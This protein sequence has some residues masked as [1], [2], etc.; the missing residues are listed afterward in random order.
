MLMMMTT[1]KDLDY[2]YTWFK[3]FLCFSMAVDESKEFDEFDEI[4]IS[5]DIDQDLDSL[6]VNELVNYIE[7]NTEQKTLSE[8]FNF[9]DDVPNLMEVSEV[10]QETGTLKE[11]LPDINDL[12]KKHSG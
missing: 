6:E 10:E 12:L 8:A 7:N 1:S 4:Y 3:F 5:D 9:Y 11:I 2:Y